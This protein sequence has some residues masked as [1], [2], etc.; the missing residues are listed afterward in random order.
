MEMVPWVDPSSALARCCCRCGE[1][2][3]EEQRRQSE[4]RIC[5]CCSCF[6]F[7]SSLS[8]CF[9]YCFPIPVLV[10][11]LFFHVFSDS[12]SPCSPQRRC[13]VVVV[14]VAVVVIVTPSPHISTSHTSFSSP[15]TIQAPP[16]MARISDSTDAKRP[17]ISLSHWC[18]VNEYLGNNRN[19]QLFL[20][21]RSWDFVGSTLSTW[22]E[23]WFIMVLVFWRQSSKLS[24]DVI[25]PGEFED[26]RN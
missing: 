2:S 24:L 12:C 9:S 16:S 21:P 11:L 23:T 1:V 8:F 13:G 15:N 17:L 3:E 14:C 7:F 26:Y 18:F 19:L 20:G 4:Y 6:C 10:L 25:F 22:D 5:L